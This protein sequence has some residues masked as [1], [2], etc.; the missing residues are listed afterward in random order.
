[1]MMDNDSDATVIL[2]CDLQTCYVLGCDYVGNIKKWDGGDRD[3][4]RLLC[5]GI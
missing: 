3:K 5:L 4:A 1:M 2:T